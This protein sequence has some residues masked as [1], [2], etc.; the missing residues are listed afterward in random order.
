MLEEVIRVLERWAIFGT[1]I[2]VIV[3]LVKT[4]G[5]RRRLNIIRFQTEAMIEHREIDW[6]QHRDRQI[7][8]LVRDGKKTEARKL[9]Q[10]LTDSSFDDSAKAVERIA[11]NK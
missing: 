5:L 6:E 3:L 7:A 10:D 1:A 4:S 8:Q 2:M 9:Y 11:S